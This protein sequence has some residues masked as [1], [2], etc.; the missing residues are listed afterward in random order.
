MLYLDVEEDDDDND[1]AYEDYDVSSESDDDNNP[2]DEQDDISTLVNPLSSTAVNQWQSTF[3]DM[4]SREQIDD[5]IESGTIRLQDW[6]NAMTDIQLGMRSVDK[7][8]A[9]SA[10]QKWSIQIGR[11]SPRNTCLVQVHQNKHRNMTSKFISKIILHLVANDPE[12]PVSNVIQEVQVLLH[13][14]CT[15]KR[16][17]YARIFAIERVFGS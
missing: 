16:A 15:Y 3:L 11:N 7:I 17:W 10:V 5:L 14:G 1:D 6:N 12:I 8:Q 4:G 2:N 13:M 9:L